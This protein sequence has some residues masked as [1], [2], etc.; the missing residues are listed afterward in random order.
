MPSQLTRASLPLLVACLLPPGASVPTPAP[1]I[2]VSNAGFE[3][4]YPNGNL[5]PEYGGD[6]PT[7]TFPTGP[8]PA[9]WTAYY[10]GGSPLPGTFL[11]VLHP[12]TAADFAPDPP[13]FELGAPEGDNAVLLYTDGDAGGL[14][15]G[16][17]QTLGEVLRADR[18]YTLRVAVGNI[19]SGTALLP[20]YSSLGF[21]DLDGFPGYRVQLLAGGVVI[22]EDVDGVLPAERQWET[23]TVELVTTASHPRLGQPL[24]IR[25]VNRNRPD[26]PGVTG[27][28]VDFDDVRLEVV[29]TKSPGPKGAPSGVALSL[30][31]AIVLGFSVL[32]AISAWSGRL[33]R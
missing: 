13:F 16:V 19:G 18:E 15:Y 17:E 30:A 4:L 31:G 28:E 8:P 29:R 20:P 27:I 6:V 23:A 11:G 2:D 1:P 3:E 25:L 12:G 24:G 7:G 26:V 32:F 21:F 9:G 14:E 33:P 22:A 10:E 5:P